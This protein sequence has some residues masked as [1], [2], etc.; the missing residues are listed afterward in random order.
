VTQG[1][2]LSFYLDFILVLPYSISGQYC[3]NYRRV[4]DQ[5]V[6]QCERRSANRIGAI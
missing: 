6:K 3:P 1:I 2:L 5:Q 4:L